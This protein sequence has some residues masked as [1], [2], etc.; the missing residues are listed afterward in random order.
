MQPLPD[1]PQLISRAKQGDKAAI[2]AL[3]RAYVQGIFRYVSY[4]VESDTV[5]EDLTA[6]VFLHMV[7]GLPQYQY[8]QAPLAAWLFRIAANQ[9]TDY[10]RR[11]RHMVVE[12]ISEGQPSDDTDPFR[13]VED[14]EERRQI[15]EAL[16]TLPEDY[17][18][19]LI[20]RFMQQLPHTE[21]AALMRKSEASIRVMQHRALQAMA[22]AIG[23]SA[24]ARSYLRGEDV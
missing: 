2:S 9:V 21:V 23:A 4:R 20:L 22:K 14:E 19:V 1:E 10:Y 7:E 13:R 12:P 8:T 17:Q 3:Y 11:K 5:A 6:E 24:K 16:K 18:T 15:R